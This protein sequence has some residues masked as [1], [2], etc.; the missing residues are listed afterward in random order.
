MVKRDKIYGL[1]QCFDSSARLLRERSTRSACDDQRWCIGRAVRYRAGTCAACDVRGG[2]RRNTHRGVAD[3]LDAAALY[4]PAAIPFYIV[5]LF[6]T[7]AQT[8]VGVL[9]GLNE[10]ID[11]WLEDTGRAALPGSVH[12]LIAGAMLLTSILLAEVGL[13]TLIAKA[14]ARWRGAFS[15]SSPYRY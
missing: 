12:A 7:I 3:V 14:M 1:Q 11:G 5:L 2:V 15:P 10:R 9:H 8:G 13:V 4:R 6:A